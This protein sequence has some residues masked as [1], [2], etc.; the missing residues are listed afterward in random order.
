MV[1]V[2]GESGQFPKVPD[3]Q[4]DVVALQIS[5]FFQSQLPQLP[6]L[7]I[8]YLCPCHINI[9][10][11][12]LSRSEIW[13][14]YFIF[15]TKLTLF[16]N[17]YAFSQCLCHK[18][19]RDRYISGHLLSSRPKISR[20]DQGIISLLV[21]CQERYDTASDAADRQ[22]KIDFGLK[23]SEDVVKMQ[24]ETISLSRLHPF[25]YKNV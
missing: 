1:K 8:Q 20:V 6:Q 9:N 11:K 16:T 15:I 18:I 7:C 24:V 22:E 19:I 3:H 2:H 13:K 23:T 4:K 5:H 14:I 12:Y 10:A 17:L 25:F 21:E